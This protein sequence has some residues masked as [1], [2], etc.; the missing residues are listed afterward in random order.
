VTKGLIESLE[1]PRTYFHDVIEGGVEIV[2]PCEVQI[3]RTMA[4]EVGWKRLPSQ[5]RFEA[6]IAGLMEASDATTVL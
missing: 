6:A 3:G 4:M 5:E 1:T 2:M